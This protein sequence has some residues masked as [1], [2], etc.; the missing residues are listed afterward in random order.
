MTL[1]VAEHIPPQFESNFLANIDQANT[2]G[3]V[4]P[5]SQCGKSKSQ[6][7]HV[8]T[9]TPKELDT[10]FMSRGYRADVNA[11]QSLRG[12]ATFPWFKTVTVFLRGGIAS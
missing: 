2:R 12:C 9:K 4:I 6:H 11:T 3:L 5:W 10:L 7:G 8:N 1:E